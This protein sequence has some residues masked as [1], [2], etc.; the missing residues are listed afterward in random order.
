VIVM[1]HIRPRDSLADTRSAQQQFI[2]LLLG[3]DELLQAEFDAII[4]AEWPGPPPSLPR[5]RLHG[6]E[7]PGSR[8]R[9]RSTAPK[10]PRAGRLP[11]LDGLA[12]ERSPPR[13]TT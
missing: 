8:R 6:N 5:R 1:S 2:E 3:D 13:T 7:D 4:A 12:R 9:H 11:H 10:E